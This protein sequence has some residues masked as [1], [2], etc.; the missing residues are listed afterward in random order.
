L[1]RP[2][3]FL[4]LQAPVIGMAQKFGHCALPAANKLSGPNSAAIVQ[5]GHSMA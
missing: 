2:A 4:R 3:C 5:K 1:R